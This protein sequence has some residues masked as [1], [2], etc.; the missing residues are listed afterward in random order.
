MTEAEY[1][2]DGLSHQIHQLLRVQPK[3]SLFSA[4]RVEGFD[5]LADQSPAVAHGADAQGQDP[6]CAV[7]APA[8]ARPLQAPLHHRAVGGPDGSRPD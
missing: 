6:L 2:S 7:V 3:L 5:V 8:L 4:G 1:F